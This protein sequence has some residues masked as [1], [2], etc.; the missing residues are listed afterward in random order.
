MSTMSPEQWKQWA[1]AD[2]ER[3]GL[4]ALEPLLEGLAAA[5]ARLRATEW[6]A[7]ADRLS[8]PVDA[9]NGARGER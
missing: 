6:Q 2:A 7:T 9:D 1:A 8:R 5:T 3:R 4:H